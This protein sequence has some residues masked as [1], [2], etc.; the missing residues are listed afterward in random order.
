VRTYWVYRIFLLALVVTAP[1]CAIGQW[2]SDTPDFKQVQIRYHI[3]GNLVDQ[4]PQPSPVQP[5]VAGGQPAMVVQ[6]SSDPDKQYVRTLDLVCPHPADPS[7]ALAVLHTQGSVDSSSVQGAGGFARRAA[8]EILLLSI[9]QR[10]VDAI[11][12]DLNNEGYFDGETKAQPGVM[13]TTVLDGQH[14]TTPWVR[15]ERL[16][17]LAHRLM[18]KGT[19]VPPDKVPKLL[20]AIAMADQRNRQAG[21]AA[22]TPGAPGA[23]PPAAG[24][25]S[26]MPTPG[27]MPAPMPG[28]VPPA[29]QPQPNMPY[30]LPEPSSYR[31]AGV[32]APA[33]QMAPQVAAM[34]TAPGYPPAAQPYP[35]PYPQTAAVPQTMYPQTAP[36]QAYPQT[37]PMQAYPQTMPAPATAPAMPSYPGQ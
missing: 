22:G 35:S 16:D 24:Y 4:K 6:P 19:Q 2:M 29:M 28:Q 33:P 36:S 1:G 7:K 21:N 10:D 14:R 13:L 15:S 17:T 23:T 20:A 27:T 32:T 12:R 30:P 26:T 18:A 31:Q 11:L 8:D 34:P 37:A 5:A 3:Q 9:R 25:P